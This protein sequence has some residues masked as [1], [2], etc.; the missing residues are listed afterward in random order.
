MKIKMVFLK[1]LRVSWSVKIRSKKKK[2]KVRLCH[3]IGS[4]C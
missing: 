1:T 2:K 3:D 4:V